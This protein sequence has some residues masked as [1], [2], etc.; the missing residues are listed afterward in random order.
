MTGNFRGTASFGSTTLAAVGN[1]DAF[2][3]RA[4]SAGID[5][6]LQVSSTSS[7]NS[8]YGIDVAYGPL[9]P[10]ISSLSPSATSIDARGKLCRPGKEGQSAAGERKG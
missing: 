6:A 2:V 7:S 10:A 4:T 8:V 1:R 9:S 5:W 3:M